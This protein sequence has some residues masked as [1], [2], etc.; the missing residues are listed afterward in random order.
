VALRALGGAILF[1]LGLWAGSC[2]ERDR[3][4]IRP[5]SASAAP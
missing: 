2:W 1:A 4:S 5:T 3:A